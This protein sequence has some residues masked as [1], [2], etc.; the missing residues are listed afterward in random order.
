MNKIN[1]ETNLQPS[2]ERTKPKRFHNNRRGNNANAPPTFKN[3]NTGEQHEKEKD[4]TWRSAYIPPR[5]RHQRNSTP[6]RFQESK[7]HIDFCTQWEYFYLTPEQD[8]WCKWLENNT[9]SC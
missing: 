7:G 6:P 5:Q 3:H 2:G 9:S 8:T 4:N 1:W